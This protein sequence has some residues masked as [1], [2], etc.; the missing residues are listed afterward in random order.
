MA[1]ASCRLCAPGK[2]VRDP[3]AYTMSL[4]EVWHRA[5]EGW[6]EAD[7]EF[8][9]VG[10][11]HPG[12]RADRARYALPA[13]GAERDHVYG[14]GVG[15]RGVLVAGLRSGRP[16]ETVRQRPSKRR[17]VKR[18]PTAGADYSPQVAYWRCL[19]ARDNR[20]PLDAFVLGDGP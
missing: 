8:H 4:D 5:G 13:R 20:V 18:A 7:T 15:P 19:Q 11:L 9:I 3:K 14:A 17:S 16:V 1:H 10:G 12:P 2:R 6:S